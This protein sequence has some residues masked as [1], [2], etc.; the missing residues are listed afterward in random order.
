M[1]TFLFLFSPS[2]SSNGALVG[3]WG[4][5]TPAPA[6]E[7]SPGQHREQLEGARRKFR[8]GPGEGGV[9]Y[10][11]RNQGMPRRD[12]PGLR[13]RQSSL[14]RNPS[15]GAWGAQWLQ[16][17]TSAQVMISR[18]VSSSPASGSVLTA[19]SLEPAS[20]S[21]S[22]SLSTPPPSVSLC[23]KNTQTL[24]KRKGTRIFNLGYK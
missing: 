9:S 3:V 10:N 13:H 22:P 11:C 7:M 5:T 16:R 21:V 4:G 2:N 8:T 18:F 6:R 19:R 12:Q 1:D 14:S 17:P 24:K 20:D 15:R 23:L